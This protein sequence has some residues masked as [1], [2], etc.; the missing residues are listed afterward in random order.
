MFMVYC[1]A[2]SILLMKNDE[3][4]KKLI[5]SLAG[6]RQYCNNFTTNSDDADDLLQDTILKALSK[7][8]HYKRDGSQQVR[9]LQERWQFQRVAAHHHAQHIHQRP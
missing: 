1:E 4:K 3:F 5:G 6:L 9:P 2:N 7:C 8:D